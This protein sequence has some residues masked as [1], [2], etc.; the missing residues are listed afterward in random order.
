M[1]AARNSARW[2]EDQHY[3]TT[4]EFRQNVAEALSCLEEDEDAILPWDDMR[5]V[6]QA[7]CIVR[8]RWDWEW[9]LA[10]VH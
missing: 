1:R 3:R 4:G 6:I 5:R 7:W 2:N 10:T 9:F 8:F